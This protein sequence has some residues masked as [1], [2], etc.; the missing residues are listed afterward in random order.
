MT[1]RP[2]GSY[3]LRLYPKIALLSTRIM[4]GGTFSKIYRFSDPKMNIHE[5][6]IDKLLQRKK[7]L[8]EERIESFS[9]FRSC[10]L[11]ALRNTISKIGDYF[12]L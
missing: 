12:V 1:G 3:K 8:N 6:R 4:G 10:L 5:V 11:K 9:Y 2:T 7:K